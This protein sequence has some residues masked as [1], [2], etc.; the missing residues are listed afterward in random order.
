MS[1][2]RSARRPPGPGRS[3]HPSPRRWRPRTAAVASR[4]RRSPPSGSMRGTRTRPRTSSTRMPAIPAAAPRTPPTAD[5][6]IPSVSICRATRQRL[7]PNAMRTAISRPRAEA[8]A[9]RRFA[10]LPATSIVIRAAAAKSIRSDDRMSPTTR[11]A[12][13]MT[14]KVASDCSSLGNSARKR[15]AAARACCRAAS[16]DTPGSSLATAIRLLASLPTSGSSLSGSQISGGV[17]TPAPS[18]RASKGSSRTPT[19]VTRSPLTEMVRPI[20]SSS[21]PSSPRHSARLTTATGVPP[22]RSSSVVKKR[23]RAGRAPK[24]VK[25]LAVTWAPAIWRA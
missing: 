4:T 13:G 15:S 1:V 19:T 21:P 18:D 24:N 25:K 3:R 7:A 5:R 2:E 14:S 6:R 8:R 11:L 10:A 23:P 22:A 17:T 20:T 16:M 12:S 9:S